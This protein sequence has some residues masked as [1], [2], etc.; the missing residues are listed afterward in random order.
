VKIG[1]TDKYQQNQTE[2][3]RLSPLFPVHDCWC[4]SIELAQNWHSGS[5]L[6][7]QAAFADINIRKG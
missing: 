3:Q 4:F 6:S 2:N 5:A 7:L 1:E